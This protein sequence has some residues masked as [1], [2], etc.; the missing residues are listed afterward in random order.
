MTG[1]SFSLGVSNAAVAMAQPCFLSSAA[2]QAATC[3]ASREVVGLVARRAEEQARCVQQL[4]DRE[5]D[6]QQRHQAPGAAAA[7][8]RRAAAAVETHQPE[9][10]G[11]DGDDVGV[12]DEAHPQA[13]Q[14]DGQQQRQHQVVRRRGDVAHAVHQEAPRPQAGQGRRPWRSRRKCRRAGSSSDRQPH[15]LLEV[16]QVAQQHQQQR[17]MEASSRR[18]RSTCWTGTG[19]RRTPLRAPCAGRRRRR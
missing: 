2:A 1:Y 3:R 13:G 9:H 17:D 5:D 16:A 14:A 7:P 10:E 15:R 19:F 12:G 4:A 11:L 6:H 18:S 8:G